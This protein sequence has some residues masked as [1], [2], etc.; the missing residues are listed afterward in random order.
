MPTIDEPRG[1]RHP[2]GLPDAESASRRRAQ[3]V[4]IAAG[5]AVPVWFWLT[6][7]LW[8][9]SPS[10]DG[11]AA[12]SAFLGFYVDNHARLATHATAFVV[13]WVLLL[14]LVVAV[15]RACTSLPGLTATLAITLA[16]A[17][18]AGAVA[19][20]GVLAWPAM[21]PGIDAGSL[22]DILDPAVAQALVLS[23]DGLHAPVA[24]LMGIA[25]VFVAGVLARSDLWGHKTMAAVTAIVGA[26]GAS[27]MVLG[28]ESLGP[29][30]ITPWGVVMAAV[31]AVDLR[32]RSVRSRRRREARR[33]AG[34]RGS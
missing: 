12:P 31:L 16:G 11:P 2:S 25:L 30:L 34:D 5:L 23:R 24:T 7:A 21:T 6:L 15:V 13:L 22:P 18:T 17:S 19:I 29:V 27:Y 33:H 4:A 28:P 10:P 1:A 20:E 3:L 14:V 32:H 9:L 26:L 8:D